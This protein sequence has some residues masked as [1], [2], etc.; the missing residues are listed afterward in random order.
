VPDS[1]YD[2]LLCFNFYVGWRAIQEFYGPAFP[3]ELN[4][5]RLYV[6]GL[7]D[8][9]G[10]SVRRISEA[11]RIDDA[12]VSNILNRLAADG[13]VERHPD[14]ADRRGVISVSTR[15]GKKLMKATDT[16]LRALDRDLARRIPEADIAAIARTV[17]ALLEAQRAVDVEK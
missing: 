5:Q 9:P 15:N 1:P 3:P 4:P 17:R 12:A 14:P 10:A 16:R 7:C 2:A 6:L 13:L 11:L 8:G